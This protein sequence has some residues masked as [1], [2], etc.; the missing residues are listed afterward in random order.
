MR[1]NI[2]RVMLTLVAVTIA[3]GTTSS[4]LT[5]AGVQNGGTNTLAGTSWKLVKFQTSDDTTL[6]PD[7]G[8]KYTVTFGSNGRITSRVDCNHA[9]STWKSS[10]PGDL[11]FG[12]W[13]RTS[14]KCGPGSLHDKIVNEGAN[15]RSYWIKDGHLFLSGMSAGG[16][17]ELEPLTAQRRRSR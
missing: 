7:D 10:R 5:L 17:Y 3:F 9:S 15:I 8:S 2:I 16:Y 11:Q 6:V 4:R 12:S 1:T 14:T 13:S